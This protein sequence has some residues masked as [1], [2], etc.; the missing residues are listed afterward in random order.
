METPI[1]Y[2]VI[3]TQEE[4][5]VVYALDRKHNWRR[6][7]DLTWCFV[8]TVRTLKRAIRKGRTWTKEATA[9]LTATYNP[10]TEFAVPVGQPTP[11]ADFVRAELPGYVPATGFVPAN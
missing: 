4:S 10:S 9:V 1:G 2:I 11:I 8:H 5:G 6:Q 3:K 7:K